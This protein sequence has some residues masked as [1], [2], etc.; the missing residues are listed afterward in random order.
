LLSQRTWALPLVVAFLG[1][2]AIALFGG[3]IAGPSWTLPTL[4]IA[5]PLLVAAGWW[6]S[7]HR[8]APVALAGS[9]VVVFLLYAALFSYTGPCLH[10][11]RED[12]GFRHEARKL[13]PLH[14][15][16]MLESAEETLEGL[17]MQFYLG[18]TIYFLHNLSFVRDDRVATSDIYVVTRYNRLPQL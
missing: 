16:L 18:D 6:F 12:T 10:G 17:R 4:L 15:P 2:I 9:F 1:D 7:L 8:R 11:A 3:R 14:E 5:F 13:V